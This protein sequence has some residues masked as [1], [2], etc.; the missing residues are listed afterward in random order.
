MEYIHTT[1]LILVYGCITTII[2]IQET[3]S[4]VCV[5]VFVIQLCN[6]FTGVDL[7]GVWWPLICKVYIAVCVCVCSLAN[8]NITSLW[9]FW[10][11]VASTLQGVAMCLCVYQPIKISPVFDL[12]GIMLCNE[13]F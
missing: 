10:S 13:H 12:F 8:Q 2:V 7:S 6:F 3:W 1:L 11:V 4:G 9:S 5:D